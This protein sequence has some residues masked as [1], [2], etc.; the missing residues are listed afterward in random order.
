MKLVWLG[1]S[2]FRVELDGAVILI[3]PFL[4]GNPKFNG[5]VAEA[6]A[7]ATHIVLTHGHDDHIGDAPD[8]AKATGAQIVANFEV[9]M[10][11]NGK[12][13]ENINPG[14]TGGS[15][16]CGAFVVSLTQALHSSG[17]T[18]NGQ[19]IY[20][21]NPNG[22]VITPKQG[23]TLYHMGDTE[24]FSDM[25]LI[26]EIYNPQIGIVPIG[27]RFTMGA[28]TAALAVRRYFKFDAVVP[29]HY[30]TFG[31]LDQSPD[32]FI[33]ALGGSG[34]KVDAPAIGGHMIY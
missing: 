7:G 27:D 34:V 13:A 22:V 16:D 14:N 11:L 1:H 4:S 20:L 19:S 3:D 31:L 32:A 29:C 24:I 25:A 10:F 9:C 2:A 23:P 12:G 21:G 5:S 18:E 15:I 8:I 30:G 17:T 33:A 28:K 6:S 26:A